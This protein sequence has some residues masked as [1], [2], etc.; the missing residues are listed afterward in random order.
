M[1]S[2]ATKGGVLLY[3]LD[4]LNCKPRNDLNIYHAKQVASIFVEIINKNKANDINGVIYRHPSMCPYN[5]N[6]NYLR[7]LMHKIA[8]D[9]NKNIFIAGDFNFNLINTNNHQET[10]DF[11]D[12][13]MS[14]FL[15][16]TI[17]LPTKINNGPDTLIDN[18]F[19]NQY[20]P[21]IISGNLTIEISDHLPSFCIFPKSNQ[22]PFTKKTQH[23]QEKQEKF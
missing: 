9:S 7:Q 4:E 17:L 20:N 21:D 8:Q 5:F 3:V 14:N 19:S 1:P 12:I 10:N 16:P 2:E 15:L 11:F 23:L 13:F 18:I 6:E 22:K